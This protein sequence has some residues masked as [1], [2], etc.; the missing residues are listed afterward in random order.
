MQLNLRKNY[1]LHKCAGLTL[2]LFSLTFFV[3]YDMVSVIRQHQPCNCEP[4]FDYID[5]ALHIRLSCCGL[6]ER[7]LFVCTDQEACLAEHNIPYFRYRYGAVL[8]SDWNIELHTI[9]LVIV[10]AIGLMGCLWYSDAR[11]TLILDEYHDSLLIKEHQI[12]IE[13]ARQKRNS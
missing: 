10:A 12:M 3:T 9:I 5:Q 13:S 4:T 2:M 7:L 1:T 8:T 11:H 6:E